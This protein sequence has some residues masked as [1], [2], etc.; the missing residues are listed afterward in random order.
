MDLTLFKANIDPEVS[1]IGKDCLLGYKGRFFRYFMVLPSLVPVCKSAAYMSRISM[2]TQ[3]EPV[4][5]N[6]VKRYS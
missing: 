1:I 2:Y 4:T 6:G 3:I 5:D